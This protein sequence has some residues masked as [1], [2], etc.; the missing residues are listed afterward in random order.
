MNV[1]ASGAPAPTQL[2]I[3][4]Q[5][6]YQDLRSRSRGFRYSKAPEDPRAPPPRDGGGGLI[7][8]AIRTAFVAHAVEAVGAT[9]HARNL[10]RTGRRGCGAHE[11]AVW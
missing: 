4:V 8:E 9:S 5:S 11:D 6:H 7:T 2:A 1:L 10:G 3:S